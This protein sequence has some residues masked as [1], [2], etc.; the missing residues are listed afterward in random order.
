[1]V[2]RKRKNNLK[3]N[4]KQNKKTA[5]RAD[6]FSFKAKLISA[7]SGVV[8]IFS[9]IL[10]NAIYSNYVEIQKNFKELSEAVL[11][12]SYSDN[13][14][15]DDCSADPLDHAEIKNTIKE[16]RADLKEVTR[17][18]NTMGKIVSL[19]TYC[20][21]H[22]FTKWNSQLQEIRHKACKTK[23]LH[24]AQVYAWRN[25]VV[26]QISEDQRSHANP[27]SAIADYFSRDKYYFPKESDCN[28]LEYASYR[29][30]FLITRKS[31]TYPETKLIPNETENENKTNK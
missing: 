15:Y 16:L 3:N 11:Y 29:P 4:K 2:S 23:I 22:E 20:T 17:K 31:I 9:T 24:K 5:P 14:L 30:N 13:V 25:Q 7:L 10:G 19:K 27:I 26:K 18:H 28:F 1:M 12:L 6:Y 8:A 21:I